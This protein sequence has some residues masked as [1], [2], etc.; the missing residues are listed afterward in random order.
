MLIFV[1]QWGNKNNN[2]TLY[3]VQ[4]PCRELSKSFTESSSRSHSRELNQLDSVGLPGFDWFPKPLPSS[5][6][7]GEGGAEGV[8]S[9]HV[10]NFPIHSSILAKQKLE[11]A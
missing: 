3:L 4:L 7:Q 10:V 11:A 6:S 2:I 5:V 8:K 1:A 9:Q